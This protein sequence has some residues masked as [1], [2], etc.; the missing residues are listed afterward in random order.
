MADDSKKP[1]NPLFDPTTDNVP[2]AEDTQSMLNKPLAGGKLSDEDQQ[3]LAQLKKLV[4]DG[5]INL[6]QPSTLLNDAVYETLPQE[7]KAKADQNCVSMLTKIRDI[8]ALEDAPMDTNYQVQNLVHSLRLNKERL[9]EHSG[10][11]FII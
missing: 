6:Y 10:D 11:I 4:A 3:F 2:I 1:I 7:G 8:L 5:T 9:E